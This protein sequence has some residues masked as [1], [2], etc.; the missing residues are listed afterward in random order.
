VGPLELFSRPREK[1]QRGREGER[2][3]E[4]ACVCVTETERERKNES[5]QVCE[6]E[7]TLTAGP[8]DVVEKRAKVA[9]Y[10]QVDILGE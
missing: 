7:S 9:Y 8:L 6:R 5:A 2:G 10:F 3:R 4:R 1:R